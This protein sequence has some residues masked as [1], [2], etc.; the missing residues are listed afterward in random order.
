[1]ELHS[2]SVCCAEKLL[3]EKGILHFFFKVDFISANGTN[4]AADK[5]RGTTSLHELQCLRVWEKPDRPVYTQTRSRWTWRLQR[6]FAKEK[7]KKN[8]RRVSPPRNTVVWETPGCCVMQRR[9]D[10]RGSALKNNNNTNET[11]RFIAQT[12]RLPGGGRRGRLG[13]K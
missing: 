4:G 13:C 7:E 12:T 10:V 3:F 8:P 5:R 1:M 9:V 2:L 6:A 11:R